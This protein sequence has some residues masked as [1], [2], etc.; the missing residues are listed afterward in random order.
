MRRLEEMR[1]QAQEE[2]KAAAQAQV[3]EQVKK[4]LEAEKAAYMGN[5]TDSIMKERM[6]TEDQRLMVQLYVSTHEHASLS[7]FLS[8]KC[9]SLT[10]SSCFSGWS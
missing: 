4:T 3:E 10:L 5:L 1:V 2:A 9:F 8:S 7:F 6:K